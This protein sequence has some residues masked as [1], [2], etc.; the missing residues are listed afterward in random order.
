[1]ADSSENDMPFLVFVFLLIAGLIIDGVQALLDFLII[2][3]ILNPLIS[4]LSTMLFSIIFLMLGVRFTTSRSFSLITTT[5]LEAL[6]SGVFPMWTGFVFYSYAGNKIENAVKKGLRKLMGTSGR[7]GLIQNAYLKNKP[8]AE[9]SP[10]QT[11]QAVR[12]MDSGV[13]STQS[14]S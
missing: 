4:L 1:M 10:V 12:I 3:L 9:P 13:R 7:A 2:G 6:P 5:V 8:V 14:P 11:Q